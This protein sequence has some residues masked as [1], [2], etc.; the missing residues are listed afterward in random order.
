MKTKSS[1]DP[2]KLIQ[3]KFF[4]RVAR[5][6]RSTKKINSSNQYTIKNDTKR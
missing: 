2:S 1:Y 3:L 5:L 4:L 6:A